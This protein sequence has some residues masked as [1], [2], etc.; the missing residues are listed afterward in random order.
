[1]QLV[2]AGL[3]VLQ[4]L[5]SNHYTLSLLT[6]LKFLFSAVVLGIAVSLA[7]EEGGKAWVV[8]IPPQ[9]GYSA[10]TGG[11]GCLAALVGAAALF[12][13]AL[14][15]LVMWVI[16]GLASLCFLAGGIVSPSC[17]DSKSR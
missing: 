13:S 11:L 3:R 16:D 15:G 1:M 12:V 7:K 6:T 14:D 2:T 10:F 5:N 4:V 17:T 8:G 9:V